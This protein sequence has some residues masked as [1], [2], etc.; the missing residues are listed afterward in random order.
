MY[1]FCGDGGGGNLVP[2]GGGVGKVRDP[3]NEVGKGE[4]AQR[5]KSY[6]KSSRCGPLRLNTLR[7]LF[8]KE[9][10]L[11]WY[12]LQQW[13]ISFQFLVQLIAAHI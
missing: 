3:G 7:H 10:S 9:V 4:G 2:R 13:S 5:L 6:L 8:Y 12:R 1:I 11:Q